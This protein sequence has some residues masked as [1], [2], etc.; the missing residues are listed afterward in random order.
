MVSDRQWAYIETIGKTYVK[1]SIEVIPDKFKNLDTDG[2][3]YISFEELLQVI[4]NYFDQKL[5]LSVEDI[6]ELNNFFFEQY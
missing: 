2:D 3:D 1:K 6:Y 5:N 4:D